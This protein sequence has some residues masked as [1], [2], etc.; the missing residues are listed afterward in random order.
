MLSF[1][2]TASAASL[3]ALVGLL[4]SGLAN[5]AG[6]QDEKKAEPKLGGALLSKNE[7][8]TDK[9][10]K[11]THNLT[12]KSPRKVYKIKL[13]QGKTYKIE[14]KSDD[15]DAVL[16]LEDPAGKEL[17]FNDDVKPGVL[18]SR[19]VYSIS[20]TAEYRII[21][22]LLDGRQTNRQNTGKFSLEVKLASEKEAAEAK[23]AAEREAAEAKMQ[24][25]LR[26]F[27]ASSLA[28]QKKIVAE[29]TKDFQAKGADVT[30]KDAQMA[31]QLFMSADDSDAA[32]LREM[33][34]TF[35]KIFDGSSNQQATTLSKFL[36][37]QMKHL[38]KIGTEMEVAGMRM[39][40]KDF[41]LKKLKGKVVL[42]DFWG[43]WCPPCVAEI[44][45]MLKA[46][47]RFHA[48]GF[49]V[50]GV[51]QDKSDEIV[52]DF[53]KAKKAPWPCINIEDSEKLIKMHNVNSYP[54]P[55]LIGADGRI[56]S[57]RARG[58]QLERLLERLLVDK[59]K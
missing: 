1:R 28:E 58:P 44:P 31:A 16:R 12:N 9:D 20:K 54:T 13:E 55:I 46:Y 39:D 30:F 25:R 34:E 43:T 49:E 42:V 57:M 22:T 48:K 37:Q 27:A 14:L 18:D 50:I 6:A 15:F 36:Q 8:L 11:D 32:W 5:H 38:D 23:L 59:S 51:P 4:W 41:D 52:M 53:L 26:M 33:G 24:A 45:N 35:C 10:E 56:V 19:I 21:A 40:G 29:A 47:E 2:R 7:E 3:L 17:A